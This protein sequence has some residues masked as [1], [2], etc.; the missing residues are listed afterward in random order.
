MFWKS[1]RPHCLHS[2]VVLHLTRAVV[3]QSAVH[4]VLVAPVLVATHGAAG[5]TLVRVFSCLEVF[6]QSNFPEEGCWV[7]G[8]C[9]QCFARYHRVAHTVHCIPTTCLVPTAWP[10]GS[11]ALYREPIHYSKSGYS[12]LFIC[13]FLQLRWGL[14]FFFLFI[15]D[16][17]SEENGP[18]RGEREKEGEGERKRE[19]ESWCKKKQWDHI[20]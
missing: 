6:L 17:F 10:T 19:C 7:R 2:C 1:A 18:S 5:N 14:F 12:G 16:A 13:V 3:C 4:G 20:F 15:S 11:Q 9:R 8:K